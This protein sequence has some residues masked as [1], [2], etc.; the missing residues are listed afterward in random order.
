MVQLSQNSQKY[1]VLW[2]CVTELTEVLCRVKT[3]GNYPR[4]RSVGTLQNLSVCFCS[5]SVFLPVP[6]A[7]GLFNN[8]VVWFCF[9]CHISRGARHLS[10]FNLFVSCVFL[11][12]HASELLAFFVCRT[13]RIQH[14]GMSVNCILYLLHDNLVYLCR[15]C[16]TTDFLTLG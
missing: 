12:V 11:S 8:Y 3:E 13:C 9:V 1:R 15:G 16:V 7:L 4:Y 5:V 6:F 14:D 2:N 10:F